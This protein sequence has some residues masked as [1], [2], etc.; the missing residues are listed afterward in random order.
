MK[1][2]L[3]VVLK[4]RSGDVPERVKGLDAAGRKALLAELKTLRATVRAWGWDRWDERRRVHHALLVA[5]AAC[6][7]GA[8]ATAAWIGARDLRDW[9]T[10]PH[11]LL[12]EVLRDRDPAWLGDVAHR[13]AA[14]AATARDDYPLIHD[15]V[16]RSGG[17]VPLTDGYVYGWVDEVARYRTLARLAEDPQTPVLVP[18]LFET[19]EPAGPLVWYEGW[20]EALVSLAERGVVERAVLVDGCVARLLRGGKP[21]DLRFFVGL[22]RRLDLTAEEEAAR[23][24]DWMALAADAPSTVAAHGLEVLARLAE[25]GVLTARQL[26]EVSASVLFRTE[27]KLVRAQLVLLG[28]VLRRDRSAAAELLPVVAEVFGHEDTAVQERA[29]KLVGRY[30]SGVDEEVRRGLAESAA[31]L[32]S[33]VHRTAAAA[34]FGTLPEA[35]GANGPY[36]ELLPPV[37]EP[38]RVAPAAGTLPELVEEVAALLQSRDDDVAA[39]ERALDGLVRHAYTDLGALREA[40]QPL[41]PGLQWYDNDFL[42]AQQVDGVQLVVL[43]VFGRVEADGLRRALRSTADPRCVH[44]RLAQVPAARGCEV[45]LRILTDPDPLPFLLATPTWHTGAIDAGELVERLAA[46]RRLG[47]RPGECDVAQALLRVRRTGPGVEAAAEAA[48]GLGTPEG[49][50]LAAWL[51][52]GEPFGPTTRAVVDTTRRY[53][54]PTLRRIVA[55]TEEQPVIQREFPPAFRALGRPWAATDESCY[56]WGEVSAATTAVLPEDREVLAAWLLPM[57]AGAAD[58]EMRNGAWFLPALAEAGGAAGPALHL[59]LGCGLG[60]RHAEDRLAAVDALLVLAARGQLDAARLGGDLAALVD[61][62]TVKPNRMA[63]AL[64]TAAGTGAYGTV[65]AVLAGALPA[66]L[67]GGEPVRGLGEI[68]ALAAECAERSGAGRD[69]RRGAEIA[70]P[71]LAEVAARKGSSRLVVQAKRLADA[72]RPAPG[73]PATQTA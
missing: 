31:A 3:D 9:R 33:P 39:F 72:L 7:G 52:G 49:A 1:E 34:V 21:A 15:L 35:D 45:A 51:T 41:L 42:S 46:Y 44:V 4:G 24:A 36:E 48:A 63:D 60:A 59:A 19:A 8:A 69:A 71:G 73:Q 61:V 18:R 23:T 56:H 20:P 29:L 62:G 54:L 28:K 40:L 38:Q 11:E 70:V 68:L 65:W 37:P 16:R 26:A 12:F 43:T 13:L 67:T 47:A 22:L 58:L 27:K 5:G 53:W 64:R 17:P 10:P 6:H 50:R 25:A 57:A 55:G 2:L 32:L 14:R 66:L 30:V